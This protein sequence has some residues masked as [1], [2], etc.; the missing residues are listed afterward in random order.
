MPQPPDSGGPPF[1]GSGL[2]FVFVLAHSRQPGALAGPTL[3]ADSQRHPVPQLV[4]AQQPEA[5]SWCSV[6]APPPEVRRRDGSR[7]HRA[8]KLSTQLRPPSPTP[9]GGQAHLLEQELPASPVPLPLPQPHTLLA[10]P[11]IPNHPKP[12]DRTVATVPPLHRERQKNM[13]AAAD[14][15]TA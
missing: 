11:L 8:K 2:P 1:G 6:L 7:P 15:G 4:S 13:L 12:L 9:D 3:Y 14:R 5:N 10:S